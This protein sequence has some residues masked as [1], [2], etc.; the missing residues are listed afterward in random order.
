[1]LPAEW[2]PHQA[3]MVSF[4]DNDPFADSVS[5]EIVKAIS[6]VMKVYC[7]I[8]SDSMIPYYSNW[9]LKEGITKDSIHFMNFGSSFSYSIRDP[10][11][12]LK[13]TNGGMAIADFAWNDYGY[14]PFDSARKNT[15]YEQSA[16]D[17]NG[18][19]NNF[20]KLFNY[21]LLSSN[22]VNE[23]GAI[24]VNGKG[25]LIQVEAVNR[26]RNP[27]MSLSQ[28]ELELKRILGVTN[29]IWLKEGV[30]DDPDGRTLIIKN[31][32]GIGVNG[33]VDEF[34]RFVNT[35][36]LFLSFPDSTEAQK[37]PVTKMTY[38]R[39]ERNF[40]ILK[41]SVDQDGESFNIIKIPVPD[42]S[43]VTYVLDSSSADPD[44]KHFSNSVKKYAQ[45]KKGDSVYFVPSRSYLNYLVTNKM[46]LI[47]KY[48]K[49]GLPGSTRQ[50]DEQVKAL[51]AT[52]FPE[53]KIIQI[54]PTGL[55]L[56]GGG[57]HC[58]TQQ[59]PQ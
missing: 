56:L 46:V 7:V 3:M 38:D 47:P 30:A 35:N 10:L 54:N 27:G 45:F 12:F 11:F 17:R 18:Y 32:F 53:R 52:Y 51:F 4:N 40:N 29:I 31:Y 36:T 16:K 23:G 33:H 57:I 43:T 25:T 19:Q 49:P 37:D 14:I 24:E 21:P 28:Q 6:P 41:Q 13:N 26:Q 50:K 15:F 42:F 5:V 20:S 8:M 1:M 44:V 58:W 9:F 55:N 39:M 2:E 59:I 48:W 22:M 34:C